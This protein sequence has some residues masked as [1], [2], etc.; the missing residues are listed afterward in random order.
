VFPSRSLTLD[1]P[2]LALESI[3]NVTLSGGKGQGERAPS[4]LTC[5]MGSILLATQMRALYAPAHGC[6]TSRRRLASW[7]KPF[8]AVCAGRLPQAGVQSSQWVL[9]VAVITGALTWLALTG[10]SGLASRRG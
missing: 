1:R 3:E 6:E 10:R 2:K 8:K 4:R 5:I 7:A 9:I